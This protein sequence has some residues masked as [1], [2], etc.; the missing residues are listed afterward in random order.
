MEI[1]SNNR[2]GM[3]MV[4]GPCDH[5]GGEHYYPDFLH[6]HDEAKNNKAKE[7]RSDSR[8]GVK[9]NGGRGG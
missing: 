1:P 3:S 5:F 8:D 6:P 4:K 7:E 2:H 9:H